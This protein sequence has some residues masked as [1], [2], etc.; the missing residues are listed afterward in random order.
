[1]HVVDG[2]GNRQLS[3]DRLDAVTYANLFMRIRI[4]TARFEPWFVQYWLMTPLVREHVKKQ[5]KGTDPEDQWARSSI[6]P[7]R[8]QSL[9]SS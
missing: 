8:S 1:M 7:A 5:T 6:D 3:A 9:P 4:D 2:R